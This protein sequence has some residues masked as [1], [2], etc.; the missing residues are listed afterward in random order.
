MS[1]QADQYIGKETP[2]VSPAPSVEARQCVSEIMREAQSARYGSRS[3]I[4]Q[5]YLD[6]LAAIIDRTLAPLRERLAEWQ[7]AA[8]GCES[9]NA[10]E[11]VIRA[12]NEGAKTWEE[13]L[14]KSKSELAPLRESLK[15][16]I[17][18]NTLAKIHAEELFRDNKRLAAELT[19]LREQVKYADL[20]L[21][22]NSS[23]ELADRIRAMRERMQ[24]LIE[25]AGG[26]DY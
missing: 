21:G 26:G 4:P 15:L 2:A 7:K 8:S 16:E 13:L 14:A 5:E 17:G 25:A 11:T 20:A 6:R 24:R 22:G 12:S 3:D 10:L 23:I 19:S 1:D 9:P 18:I